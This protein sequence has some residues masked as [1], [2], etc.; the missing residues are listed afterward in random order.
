MKNRSEWLD[1]YALVYGIKRCPWRQLHGLNGRK[2]L[3]TREAESIVQK[4]GETYAEEID[5]LQNAAVSV[6]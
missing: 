4:Q 2:A 1:D 5:V 3:K 6:L